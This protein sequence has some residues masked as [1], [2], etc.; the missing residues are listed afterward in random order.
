[1][2]GSDDTDSG[3]EA[4]ADLRL[5][6]RNTG[7]VNLIG[8]RRPWRREATFYWL[9]VKCRPAATAV[10]SRSKGARSRMLH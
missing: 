8:R 7:S 1:M 9:Q 10:E 6:S 4:V 3:L 2:H 5:Q